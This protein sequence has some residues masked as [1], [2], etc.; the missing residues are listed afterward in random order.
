MTSSRRTWWYSLDPARE[1]FFQ[2]IRAKFQRPP[3]QPDPDPSAAA[4]TPPRPLEQAW[5][6]QQPRPPKKSL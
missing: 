1:K 6:G 2:D 3:L 5:L 4:A